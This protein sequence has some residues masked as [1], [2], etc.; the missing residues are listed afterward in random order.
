MSKKKLFVTIALIITQILGTTYAQAASTYKL[1]ISVSEMEASKQIA[2]FN[3]ASVKDVCGARKVTFLNKSFRGQDAKVTAFTKVRVK[4]ESGKIIG[5]GTLSKIVWVT[6]Y[7]SGN[8]I[9]GSCQFTATVTV[10][11]AEFYTVEL[12]GLESYDF[13][14][15]ELKDQKWKVAIDF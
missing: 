6:D 5:T 12:V 4:N 8:L 1:K 10:K 3:G 9:Q 2:R 13:S 15:K 11:S 14:L 7:T